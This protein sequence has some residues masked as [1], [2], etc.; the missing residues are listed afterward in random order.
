MNRNQ[1]LLAL[2]LADVLTAF[3][4]IGSELFFGWTLPVELKDFARDQNRAF[5]TGRALFLTPLWSLTVLA[6]VVAW[7]GLLNRWWFARRLYLAA[8]I[9]WLFLLLLSGPSVM[10]ALGAMFSTAEAAIGG[11]ILALVY[12]SE[13]SRYFERPRLQEP[14]TARVTG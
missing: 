8:W 2:V 6:T 1:M 9:T 13:L 7:V 4:S 11:A 12:F 5:F 14:A 10:T 3:A